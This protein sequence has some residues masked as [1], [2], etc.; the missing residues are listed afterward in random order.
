M[1]PADEFPI[2]S[3]IHILIY[4]RADQ[5][6]LSLVDHWVMGGGGGGGGCWDKMGG[7]VAETKWEDFQTNYVWAL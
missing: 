1:G 6:Y 4:A 7:G 2:N 5:V 3:P